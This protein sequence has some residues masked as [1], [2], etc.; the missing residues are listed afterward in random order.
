MHV[1][2]EFKIRMFLRFK[3]FDHLKE[4][5]FRVG[6]LGLFVLRAL[7]TAFMVPFPLLGRLVE[8]WADHWFQPKPSF[9][10]WRWGGSEAARDLVKPHGGGGGGRCRISGG[11]WAP[12]RAL[13]PVCPPPLFHCSLGV[14]WAECWVSLSPL[15]GISEFCL[16]ITLAVCLS[17]AAH[18]LLACLWFLGHIL[19]GNTLL[20]RKINSREKTVIWST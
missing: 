10:R 6:C 20:L 14:V 2:T 7:G 5:W 11:I 12:D 9:Y 8:I 4:C 13:L 19:F 17:S 1:G 3:T 18:E 16:G 15:L